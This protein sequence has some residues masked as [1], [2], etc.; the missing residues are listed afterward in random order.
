M[1]EPIN[2]IRL[3][4]IMQMF[5]V[6]SKNFNDGID[7]LSKFEAIFWREVNTLNEKLF[8]NSSSRSYWYEQA[9]LPNGDVVD[10]LYFSEV[11][12]ENFVRPCCNPSACCKN[13]A[14]LDETITKSL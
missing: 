8:T 14:P 7:V 3:D 13:K 9:R 11:E 5:E 1:N 10:V 2:E 4:L 6:A 12:P